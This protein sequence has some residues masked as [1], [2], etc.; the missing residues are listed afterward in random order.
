MELS[1]ALPSW[2]TAD[3]VDSSHSSIPSY[4]PDKRKPS[5]ET[6][7]M[8][9]AQYEH[10]FMRVISEMAKGQPLH[11]I[12]AQEGRSVDY[13]DFY[14]WMKKD[15]QRYALFQ[16]A[17]ELRSEFHAGEILQIADAT[18]SLE[19]VQ[20]SR[21]R[22]ETRRWL[23]G[24]HNKKRY[25]ESKQIEMNTSISITDALA[26]ATARVVQ[27]EVID[28]NPSVLDSPSLNPLTFQPYEQE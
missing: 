2:L 18:D 25:G 9:L 16:E 6:R 10:V 1:P 13:N 8:V 21:L 26:Q 20:R 23:M 5:P 12:L 15:A 22:I 11:Q 28:H 7:E 14:R 24:A 17:Q 4:D 19:D 27:G 3:A